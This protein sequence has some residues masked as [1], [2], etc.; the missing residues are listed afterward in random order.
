MKYIISVLIALS[1][2]PLS[3]Y[4][5]VF[6]LSLGAV[7]SSTN[8][9]VAF[10]ND[11]G[12][13]S[14]NDSKQ[15]L[16]IGISYEKWLTP[17]TSF[18]TGISYYKSGGKQAVYETKEARSNALWDLPDN[19]YSIPYIAVFGN[20]YM[21]VAKTNKLSLDVLGGFHLDAIARS[22]DKD[23]GFFPTYDE[24][25]PLQTWENQGALNKFNF[26][27]NFGVR[28]KYDFEKYS[29]GLQLTSAPKV[30]KL[31]NYRAT[32]DEIN[33]MNSGVIGIDVKEQNSFINF[34]FGYKLIKQNK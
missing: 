13:I 16:S 3:V 17:K 30:L 24:T 19:Q 20:Y 26:G 12:R 11:Y 8:H 22:F 33:S 31:A 14:L 9:A 34:T 28:L 15:G 10:K 4:S 18:Q 21:S 25:D 23:D 29:F 27:P 2:L 32:E 5:Q 7:Q 6:N 1:V